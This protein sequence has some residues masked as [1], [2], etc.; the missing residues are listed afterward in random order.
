MVGMVG[1]QKE[2]RERAVRNQEGLCVPNQSSPTLLLKSLTNGHELK[3][4]AAVKSRMAYKKLEKASTALTL[5]A[6][7][8]SS[9]TVLELPTPYVEL[10]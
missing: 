5:T 7:L 8:V 10:N 1:F 3:L 6:E 4:M 9:P 2:D